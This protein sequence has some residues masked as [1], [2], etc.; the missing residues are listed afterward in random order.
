MQNNQ[1]NSKIAKQIIKKDCLSSYDEAQYY[2]CKGRKDTTNIVVLVHGISRNAKEIITN[3]SDYM[4]QDTLLIAPVFSKEYA[5]DY[6]RLGRKNKGPRADYILQ[7][8]IN[9]LSSRYAIKISK[10][11]LFG[12]SA[13]AQ[14]VHRYAFAHPAHVGKVAIVAAGWYT[15]PVLNERYPY[16]LKLTDE[17][18]D[19][20]FERVRFLRV[21]YRVYVGQKDYLRDK[22]LNKSRKVDKLQGQNRLERAESW[23][24]RMNY[25]L[26]KAKLKN[27]VKLEVLEH[28][29][30]DFSLA[31]A[32]GSLCGKVSRWFQQAD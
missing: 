12:F 7:A 25:Y 22:S 29:T 26:E 9:E 32:L 18:T 30:H 4:A 8:V 27:R 23:T 2:Y 17:F 11:N 5:T 13:G 15:M 1:E 14:F 20:N 6:Q 24:N 21:K 28:V 3:F 31:D 10:I 16:G 19:I